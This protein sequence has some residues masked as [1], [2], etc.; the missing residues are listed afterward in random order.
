MRVALVTPPAERP[1]SLEEARLH[2]RAPAD[3]DNI[4]IQ[5]L[6]DAA[7]SHLDG[8]SGTLGR[9]LIEQTWAVH[10]GLWWGHLT[11]PFP[12]ARDIVVTYRDAQG[13]E[14]TVDPGLV[15]YAYWGTGYG[16][17]FEVLF[18]YPALAV[19]PEPITVTF[20]SGYE[21]AAAVPAAIKQ[22]ILLLVGHWYA[23]REAV[24]G[25]MQELPL[26]VNALLAPF[27]V[28]RF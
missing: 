22:A 24:A 21:D 2:L 8:Y 27:R 14:R 3:E 5:G 17:R 20:T 25:P 7:V 13:V 19:H 12:D 1:V 28:A 18:N 11:L 15:T 6:I 26:A 16:I 4:L 23:N 9:C 10:A